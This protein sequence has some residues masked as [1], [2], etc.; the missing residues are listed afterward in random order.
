MPPHQQRSH[1]NA[2]TLLRSPSPEH[3]RESETQ[4]I[5]RI[6]GCRYS[7]HS[8]RHR[9]DAALLVLLWSSRLDEALDPKDRRSIAP[10]KIASAIW[11]ISKT[12]SALGSAI[13]PTTLTAA[14]IPYLAAQVVKRVGTERTIQGALF[15]LLIA[16]SVFVAVALLTN[17]VPNFFVFYFMTL[18][19]V[20]ADTSVVPL[21]T[22]TALEDVGHIAGTAV[23]TVGAISLFGGSV[24]SGF[25][26]QAID[27]TVTPFAVGYL[28]AAIVAIISVGWAQKAKQAHPPVQPAQS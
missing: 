7:G 19:V 1:W 15:A 4:R 17:G 23:S 14:F 11:T 22:A 21:L 12:P 24:L 20:A 2:A 6:D 28:I 13:A 27:D 25:I 3:G 5:S 26:D 16:A 10:R 18:A 9:R 8:C